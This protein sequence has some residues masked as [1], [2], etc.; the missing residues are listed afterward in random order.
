MRA[1]WRVLRGAT[2]FASNVTTPAQQVL[3]TQGL[4]DAERELS[5][6]QSGARVTTS[7]Q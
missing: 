2:S 6:I 1:P 7:G 4:D 5:S 3:Q